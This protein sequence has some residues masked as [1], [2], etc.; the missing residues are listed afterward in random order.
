MNSLD[1][2]ETEFDYSRIFLFKSDTSRLL[3][4]ICITNLRIYLH[5]NDSVC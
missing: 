3:C 4:D 1:F 5:P 2:I